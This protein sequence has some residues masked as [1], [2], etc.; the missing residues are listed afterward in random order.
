MSSEGKEVGPVD[1][2]EVELMRRVFVEM[3][4]DGNFHHSQSFGGTAWDPEWC[5]RIFEPNS[6]YRGDHKCLDWRVDIQRC[7]GPCWRAYE[8]TLDAA[9]ESALSDFIT[10]KEA[11]RRYELD[12]PLGGY[13]KEKIITRI[14][15]ME[16]MLCEMREEAEKL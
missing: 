14:A 16:T 3:K 12:R 1:E 5:I 10:A 15:A 13:P 8:K 9:F 7:E 6:V 2:S 11:E 4:D